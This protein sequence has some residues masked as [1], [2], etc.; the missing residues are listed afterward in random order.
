[1]TWLRHT[2]ILGTLSLPRTL[3]AP[4]RPAPDLA[5]KAAFGVAS[6]RLTPSLDGDAAHLG[7]AAART[8]ERNSR[9]TSRN[10]G[11]AVDVVRA[12]RGVV[13]A[14][15]AALVMALAGCSSGGPANSGLARTVAAVGSRWPNCTEQITLSTRTGQLRAC[16]IYSYPHGRL[17][18]EA[19]AAEFETSNGYDLPHFSFVFRQAS[20]AAID[21]RYTSSV[22]HEENVP[23]HTT[24]VLHLAKTAAIRGGD[25]LQ[26]SLLATNANTGQVAQMAS[27]TLTLYPQGLSCPALGTSSGVGEGTGQC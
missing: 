11:P 21:Y 23:S 3:L 2:G 18:V 14:I 17:Q 26:V 15:C 8:T 9:V 20:S 24:G 22:L 25:I 12:G 10:R 7:L 19:V 1:L 6:D 5:V 27:V 13:G 4:D 16:V